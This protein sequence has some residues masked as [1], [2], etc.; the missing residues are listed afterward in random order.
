MISSYVN[1]LIKTIYT[2]IASALFFF[3]SNQF[4]LIYSS[5]S[6]FNIEFKIMKLKLYES[7]MF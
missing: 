1:S 4:Y 6:F 7:K 5:E 2:R 3:N